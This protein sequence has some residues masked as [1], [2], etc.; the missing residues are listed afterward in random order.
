MD[1]GLNPFEEAKDPYGSPNPR[2][3][4]TMGGRDERIYSNLDQVAAYSPNRHPSAD[5]RSSEVGG[6]GGRFAQIT[7]SH[8]RDFMV[9]DPNLNLKEGFSNNQVSTT[10]YN[11][12]TFI[13][14]NLFQ[15]FSKFANLYFLFLC[16]L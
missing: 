1:G 3:R 5:S 11:W 14:L 10:K 9:N 12:F 16:I 8:A 7:G 6:E 13:P 15:Q 4:K 2:G